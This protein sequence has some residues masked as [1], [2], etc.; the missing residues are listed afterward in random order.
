[1]FRL[2]EFICTNNELVS[3][4]EERKKIKSIDCEVPCKSLGITGKISSWKREERKKVE[5]IV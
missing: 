3:Q 4:D 5:F 2:Y 1:M